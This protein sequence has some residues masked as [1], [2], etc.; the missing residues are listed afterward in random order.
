MKPYIVCHMMSS[1]DG[2]ID[3]D[4]T[5]RI[6]GD[7][8]YEALD[9][10][11]CDSELSG[12]VTMQMHFALP[13]PFVASDHTPL[14]MISFYKAIDAEG[15]EI[16]LDS[17]GKLKWPGNGIEK[18]K[19]LL[20]ITSEDAPVEYL[21]TLCK[22]DISWIAAGNGEVDLIR[23]VEMLNEH[24]GVKRLVVV[25]GGNINGSFLRA[26]LLDEVSLVIGAGIDGRKGM[27]AVFDGI[28]D[29]SFPT[30]I[31]RLESVERVGENS[32]WLRYFC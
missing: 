10:L 12:R 14:G 20:V 3:C 31:L 11:H 30:V 15:Y 26:G 13:E 32:V 23:A 28:D 21:D 8:Y 29:L 19:P 5:E 17:K 1:V 6:G 24:F 4:M 2:R 7:E 18:G 27:T 16:G 9:R 25:G 22:Q